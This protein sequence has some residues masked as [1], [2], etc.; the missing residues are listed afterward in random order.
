MATSSSIDLF[1]GYFQN[2]LDSFLYVFKCLFLS[3]SFADSCRNFKA[4]GG[5]ASFFRLFKFNMKA[6]SPL[7]RRLSSR[8]VGD[9]SRQPQQ[10]KFNRKLYIL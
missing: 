6:G 7:P 3:I 2:K 9:E 10:S 5:I 8:Q 4:L 1:P